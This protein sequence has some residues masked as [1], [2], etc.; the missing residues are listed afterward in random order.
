MD[1]VKKNTVP[2]AKRNTRLV[3]SRAT[4]ETNP[5][6]RRRV[7]GLGVGIIHARERMVHKL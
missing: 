3:T 7:N 6:C 1:E 2:L 5:D 4:R